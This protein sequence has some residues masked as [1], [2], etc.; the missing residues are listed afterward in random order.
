MTQFYIAY[1]KKKLKNICE[2]VISLWYNT[3]INRQMRRGDALVSQERGASHSN[4]RFGSTL[5]FERELLL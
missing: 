2:T 4:M 3:V 5:T 1:E